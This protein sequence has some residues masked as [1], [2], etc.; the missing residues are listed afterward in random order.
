MDELYP[1]VLYIFVQELISQHDM[2]TKDS[3]IMSIYLKV[4]GHHQTFY[5]KK[6]KYMYMYVTQ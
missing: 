3:N 2:Y 6:K 4:D 1:V 5:R